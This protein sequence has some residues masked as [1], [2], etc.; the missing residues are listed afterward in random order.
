[1]LPDSGLLPA[2]EASGLGHKYLADSRNEVIAMS[3]RVY[4]ARPEFELAERGTGRLWTD[5][6]EQPTTRQILGG[7]ALP[8]R[9][10]SFTPGRSQIRT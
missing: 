8:S 7:E 1:L 3:P 9:P 5:P 4:L 10:G 6:G 2:W